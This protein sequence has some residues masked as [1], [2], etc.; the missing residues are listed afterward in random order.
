[1]IGL[2]GWPDLLVSFLQKPSTFIPFRKKISHFSDFLEKKHCKWC[3]KVFSS[4]P[5]SERKETAVGP[6]GV[7]AP[8]LARG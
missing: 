4:R 8:V 2:L 6:L 1:M 3:S 5:A 7:K